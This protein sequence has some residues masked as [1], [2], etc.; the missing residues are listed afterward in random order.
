MLC[1]SVSLKDVLGF[2]V[3]IASIYAASGRVEQGC[4]IPL[5]NTTHE[6]EEQGPMAGHLGEGSI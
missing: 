2:T 1:F 5:G 3:I 6:Q 4:E